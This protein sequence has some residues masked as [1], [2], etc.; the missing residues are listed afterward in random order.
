M[1]MC[2]ME[3]CS[4]IWFVNHLSMWEN[5]GSGRHLSVPK[6]TVVNEKQIRLFVVVMK[7]VTTGRFH[8]QNSINV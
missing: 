8:T 6:L 7:S 4:T 3:P 2:T 1:L 5:S